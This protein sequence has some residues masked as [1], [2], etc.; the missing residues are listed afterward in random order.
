L[1]EKRAVFLDR[2]GVIN[3][4]LPGDYVRSWEQFRF[5]RG[6]RS[7]LRL[8]REAG[9]LLIVFTNQRGIALGLMTEDD[10]AAIHRRMQAELERAGAPLDAIYHCPH[11]RDAGCACRKPR[12]GMLAQAIERFSV[13]PARSW[14]VG[15][16]PA[17]LEAGRA[18]GIPGILVVPRGGERPPGSRTAGSL[19]AAARAI[20]RRAT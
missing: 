18:V 11:D 2:D 14:V 8:L 13:D 17:D 16:T 4:R 12:P 19:L 9:F 15:D 5:L 10:L 3:R 1:S 20:A 7:G 6:V